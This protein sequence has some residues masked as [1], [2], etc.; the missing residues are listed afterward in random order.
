MAKTEDIANG[1]KVSRIID[2]FIRNLGKTTAWL[3]TFL[4]INIL[5]Q[6]ILR[7]VLGAGKI[8]LEELEWHF[9][10]VLIMFGIPYCLTVDSHIRLDL[11]YNKFS[12]KK[13]ATFELLGII[14]LIL[15]LTVIL[16]MHGADFVE[17]AWRVHEKS[18]HPL[19]LPWRWL[20]KSVIPAS[21]FLIV[22]ASVSRL[23]RSVA[24]IFQKNPVI[25]ESPDGD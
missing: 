10:G 20:I 5:I 21:M 14:I 19:G 23:I 9:Y 6:V 25:E 12:R 1:P 3:N 7:Y 8:W 2:G 16:F 13:K 24:I 22:L 17:S 15:P 18:A 11:L 4:V